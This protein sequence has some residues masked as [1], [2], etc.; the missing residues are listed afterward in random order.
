MSLFD[1]VKPRRDVL[2]GELTEARFAASLEE[3]ISGSAPDAYGDPS[4]FFASTY[5]S[6]GLKSLLNEAI[7]RVTGGRPDAASVIRLETNLGGGKTHNLIALYHAVRG[8]LRPDQAAELM[9]PKLLPKTPIKQVGVFVGTSAGASSFPAIDGVA[10]KTIWGYLA[11]QLGGKAGY[12]IVRADDEALTAPGSDAIKRLLGDE[13]SLILIDEIARYYA[14]AKGV[15]VG[16]TT[17]AG[18]TTAFLMA[19]M[20]AVDALPHAALVITTTGLTDAFGD[21][22]AD[23]LTAIDE[24]RELMARKELVLRPS[25]EADL[26]KILARRLFEPIPAGVATRVAKNYADAAEAAFNSGLDLPEGMTTAGWASEVTN[27]YPFHPAFIRV[28]DKRLSTIPNFQRTRGALRLLARVVRELWHEKPEGAQLI[29]LHHVN[30]ADKVIAEELSSRLER[31]AY[32]PVIRADIATQGGERSHADAIDQHMGNHYAR[33]LA[34]GIYLY[35]LTRDV[36]GVP[37]SELY[38]ATLSP[39]DDPNLIQRSLDALESACW[40]LHADIRGFRFSTEASLVKLIQ[41]AETEIS[42]T[43]ARTEATSI[44]A[45]RFKDAALKVKRAWEDAKVPDSD[46]DAWLVIVHWDEFGDHRGVDPH[47]AIPAK[48]K[49]LWDRTPSGGI[50]EYR[51]RLV[52]LAP[53]LATHEAMVRSVRTRLALAALEGNPDVLAALTPDKRE[54]LK[55]RRKESD[56][57]AQIA[58][59]NHMNVLYVPTAGGLESIELDIVTQA[60]AR[61]NQ[62]DAILDRLASMDKTLTAGSKP[63]DPGYVKTKL[64]ELLQKPQPT[65][66]L[67]RAFARRTDL[68]MVLDRAQLV[69]LVGAGVRNG[70]WEYHDPE[71][72]DEGWAT[73]DH[74]NTAVRLAEDTF[75]YPPGSAPPPKQLACPFCGASHPGTTCAGGGGGGGTTPPPPPAP[76]TLFTG[77][78][79]AGKAFADARASAAEASR[80]D[81]NEISVTIDHV[82]PGAGTELTRLHTVVN[83]GTLGATLHYDVDAT[84]ALSDPNDSIQIRFH[85]SPT[86]YAPLREA[87]KQLLGPRQATLKASVTAHWEGSIP[88]S[89]EAVNG[90][91]QAATDTGPTKCAIAITTEATA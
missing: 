63:L 2:D 21:N 51:N 59:C 82:G 67:I 16:Q 10:A 91:A 12:Q 19:L 53:S 72:G 47:T 18:Q 23:V 4:A 66:E 5:P 6:G 56:L 74:P 49:E 7:G 73:K 32:E 84:I 64:G 40:Y 9:D 89:G 57:L 83:P 28:L 30:L 11:L 25:G 8:G 62:T 35:S 36:P 43:K 76:G 87:L 44:L 80:H 24:A 58:V 26:P 61:P 29:H 14:V 86:E 3:V 90:I 48:V 50:R 52:I 22:T 70:V 41:E 71:R 81:L 78:G 13:P 38:G 17:L 75:I 15:E 46:E 69:A 27:T 55:N 88:L 65:K 39:G 34:T 54:E 45:Q 60:S 33:R 31:A 68:K 37:A 79:S 77:A 1:D 85:G 20:E 42:I